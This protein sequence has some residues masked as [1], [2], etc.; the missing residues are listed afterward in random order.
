MGN[1]AARFYTYAMQ[2]VRA[3]QTT[4]E[5]QLREG[6]EQVEKQVL[7]LLAQKSTSNSGESSLTNVLQSFT[8]TL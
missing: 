5:Q 8:S 2:P 3:L 6:V 1:Y 4:L 7:K